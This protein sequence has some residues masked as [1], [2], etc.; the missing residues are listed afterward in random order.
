MNLAKS[1]RVIEKPQGG[2]RIAFS[3]DQPGSYRVSIYAV[4]LESDHKIPIT[5]T[6]IGAVS[7]GDILLKSNQLDERFVAD[8]SLERPSAGAYRVV[9]KEVT[10]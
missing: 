9:C 7:S 8:I 5:K 2:H 6:T 3:L 4:G 1:S 10:S